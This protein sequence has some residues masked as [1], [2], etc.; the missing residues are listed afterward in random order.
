[1]NA[2][3]SA[4]VRSALYDG[5]RVLGIKDGFEGLLTDQVWDKSFIFVI[6]KSLFDFCF[7]NF[8]LQN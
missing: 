2:A 6:I 8:Q 5:H 4:F 1:M 3:V 7:D